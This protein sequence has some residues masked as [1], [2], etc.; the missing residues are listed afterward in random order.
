MNAPNEARFDA[1]SLYREDLYSDRKVG[2]IRQ[3]TPVR[4]DG[5]PDPKRAVQFVGQIS[6]LTPMGTLP[7]TFELDGPT[8]D[9][10]MAQFAE[11]AKAAMEDAMREL[12]QLRRE[13]ASSIIVPETGVPPGGAGRI[14]VP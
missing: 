13:A 8:L 3:L 9:A 12:Q 14:R 5:S 1:D 2:S 4:P 7:I 10:A 11:A 6:V